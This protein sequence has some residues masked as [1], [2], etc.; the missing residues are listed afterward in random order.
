MV[1]VFSWEANHERHL[2]WM[3]NPKHNLLLTQG[4]GLWLPWQPNLLLDKF[5]T[6]ILEIHHTAMMNH[7]VPNN[8]LA[9]LYS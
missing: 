2:L 5:I 4:G 6:V 1:K 3:A 8:Q 9:I 7:A